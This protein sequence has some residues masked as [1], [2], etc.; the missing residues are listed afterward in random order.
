LQTL[1]RPQPD[2]RSI[3][4]IVPP[5][6]NLVQGQNDVPLH[7]NLARSLSEVV[8]EGLNHYSYFEGVDE[9]VGAHQRLADPLDD[10]RLEELF[11]VLEVEVGQALADARRLGD[12]FQLGGRE[13][14]GDEQFQCRASDLRG[15]VVRPACTGRRF[16]GFVTDID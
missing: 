4:R 14:L 3:S 7:A 5:S 12:V 16:G 1:K 2:I 8:A 6:G 10:H 15:A 13:A 9:L 11:L